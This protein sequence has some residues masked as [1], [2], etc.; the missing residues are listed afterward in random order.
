MYSCS[1]QDEK[2]HHTSFGFTEAKVLLAPPDMAS[3]AGSSSKTT[4]AGVTKS[5]FWLKSFVPFGHKTSLCLKS[6]QTPSDNR[7]MTVS[8]HQIVLLFDE[9]FILGFLAR[10]DVLVVGPGPS[11]LLL[12]RRINLS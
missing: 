2:H 3:R 7:I 10:P 12:F 9:I 6:Y 1:R 4:K 8:G 11:R 5:K